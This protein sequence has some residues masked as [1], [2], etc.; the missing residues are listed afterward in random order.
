[1]LVFGLFLVF[2]ED[3]LAKMA[4]SNEI[5]NIFFGGRYIVTMMGF[6]SIYT[7]LIYND[8]F[9]KS[10]NIFGSHWAYPNNATFPL[11][12]DETLML[13]PGNFTQYKGD[14]Y[15]FGIGQVSH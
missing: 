9:S 11:K 12:L 10:L 3:S 13:D 14:P 1:M 5:F 8:V 6:F 15:V 2:K 7:G 4:G